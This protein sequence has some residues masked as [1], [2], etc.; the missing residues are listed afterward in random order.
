MDLSSYISVGITYSE[1]KKRIEKAVEEE[2]I[3]S[4]NQ[5]DDLIQYS[6]LNLHRMNRVEKSVT[7]DIH[8]K[9]A[10][11]NLKEELTWLVISEGWCGDASQS[12]PIFAKIESESE[13]K[14]KMKIVFRDDNLE[15]MDQYLT[16]GSRSIPKL[17]CL[18]NGKPLWS[19]G[20]RPSAANQLVKEYKLRNPE[21]RKGY[22]EELHKWYAK[23]RGTEIQQ[24]LL[25]LIK[26]T[27]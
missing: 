20:A 22:A 8:L 18:K 3:D 7:L 6:R 24:E 13:N 23:D 26:S 19:W 10:L 25:Q 1:Y 11:K 12:L 17:I 27:V 16:E 15:L 2:Q 4:G 14:I 9:S 5:S 21:N